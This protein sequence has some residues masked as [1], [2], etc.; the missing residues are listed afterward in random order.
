MA[1][2]VYCG[3]MLSL[4]AHSFVSRI[5]RFTFGIAT[6]TACQYLHAGEYVV[7]WV[8]LGVLS[9]VGLGTGMHSGLLF[10]FP[11]VMRVVLAAEK[12]QSL[13]F[14]THGDMWFRTSF[15]NCPAEVS[16]APPSF[17][18]IVGKVST[19]Q[20]TRPTI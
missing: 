6:F 18:A 8:G 20:C 16:G 2:L 10:L 19:W 12:C 15:F 3:S 9:S 17:W 5:Y 7:W 14:T 11:H 4:H 13:D 1:D